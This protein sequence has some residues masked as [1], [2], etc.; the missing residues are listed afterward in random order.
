[1]FPRMNRVCSA[2]V[3]AL[4]L[5]GSCIWAEE[6][7]PVKIQVH[8]DRVIRVSRTKPTLLLGASP[9]LM[10]GAPLHDQILKRVEELGADDVRS[11]G[12]GYLY[13]HFGVAELEPPTATTTSWDFSYIDPVTEDALQAL[14]GHAVVWNFTTI[15]AWMFKTA[16]PVSYPAEPTKRVWDYELCCGRRALTAMAV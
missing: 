11:T 14:R 15:P 5:A 3:L 13:P 8:W 9:D 10:R 1:M 6:A 7:Q 12:A 16:K 4:C 2:L